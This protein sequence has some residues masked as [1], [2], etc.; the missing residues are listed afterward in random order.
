MRKFWKKCKSFFRQ[1]GYYSIILLVVVLVAV[2]GV[3]PGY[4]VDSNKAKKAA[5]AKGLRKVKVIGR[6]V[7]FVQLRGC[8]KK[9]V[10]RFKVKGK[11]PYGDTVKFYVCCGWP[12]KGCKSMYK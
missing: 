6:D 2:V 5:K 8:D 10:V 12:F 11:T 4:L 1:A 7:F 3:L 9:D